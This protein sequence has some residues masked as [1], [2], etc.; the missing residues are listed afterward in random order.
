M[1]SFSRTRP[2]GRG[3][4]GLA[5]VTL[6]AV[7]ALAACGGSTSTGAGPTATTAPADTATT[8]PT[9]V[10][11]TPAASG[12][13]TIAMGSF[14]FTNNS[15][16]IKAG[17][18]VTFTSNGTHILVTGTHGAFSSE[19]GAPS[20]FNNST[21]TPFSPGDSKTVVFANAGTFNITCM[22]HPSMQA[23]VT[24]TP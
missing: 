24:V 18:S 16:T 4:V 10:A 1:R 6:L 5:G 15:V 7:L 14:S 9:A 22:I 2:R 8:A 19:A 20:E 13:A 3:A 23:T 17:Q 21:G 12:A 11:T